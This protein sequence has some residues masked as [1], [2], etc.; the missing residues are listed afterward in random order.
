[1]TAAP[2]DDPAVAQ[3]L[4]GLGLPG[5][6]DIHTH[7]MPEPVLRKVQAWFDGIRLPN[8]DPAWPLTYRGT[9]AERVEQLR[10][11]G[12][13]GFTALSYPHK[14]GMATWLNRWAADFAVAVPECA[15]SATYF[16][17][18]EVSAYVAEAIAGG[19]KVFK[20]HLQVGGYD[21]RD[22]LLTPVWGQVAEARIPVVTHCASGPMPGRFT[23]LEPIAE[24]LRRHPDLTVVVAHMGSPE[25]A[26]FLALALR[27]PN[28]HLDTTMA[29]T[30]FMEQ[31]APYP[32]DLLPVLR[33]HADRI[34]LGSDFPNIPHAYAHQLDALARLDLGDEWLRAVCYDNGARLLGLP[35][36]SMPR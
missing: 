34:V 28:V 3:L 30:D 5:L 9:D 19:A 25:F 8:G 17:E 15:R 4:T 27:H 18:P 35:Q 23:G 26:E 24:V 20:V 22:P 16:P 14:P 10:A 6:V 12:V 31:V 33:D 13:T 32:R 7:F 36:R 29:F 21:P 2:A 11:F 1:M